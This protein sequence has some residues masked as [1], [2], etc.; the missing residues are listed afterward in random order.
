MRKALTM[1]FGDKAEVASGS[2]ERRSGCMSMRECLMKIGRQR[3][4]AVLLLCCALVF[5]TFPFPELTF[6]APASASVSKLV[7]KPAET[8]ALSEDSLGR[9]TPYGTV[10]GF[11]SAAERKDYQRASQ[12]LE[13]AQSTKK[14]EEL[15]RLLKLVLDRGLKPKWESL[16]RTPEGNL[17]EGILSNLE[18]V[19]T[20][21]Y[22]EESLDIILRRVD[23]KGAASIWLFSSE[24]LSGIPDA[25]EQ[26]IP[27]FVEKILPKGFMETRFGLLPLPVWIFIIILLPLL[28]GFSWLLARGLI[29]LLRPML[30][31]RIKELT[32]SDAAR[33]K[34]PITLLI[35]ALLLRMLAPLSAYIYYRMFW[36]GVAIVL[37]IVALT[38]FL[39]RLTMLV[40]G[41]R[42][43]RLREEQLLNQIALTELVTWLL[44]GLW[45]IVGLLLLLKNAGFELTTAIAGLSIFGV[46]IAFAAQKTIENLFGAVTVITDEPIRVGDFCQV[47]NIEG[48]VESIGL[49][50][51]RIRTLNRTL[52]T[53]PN[54]QL[55]TMSIENLAHR[56]KFLFRHKF[57]LRYETTAEQLSRVLAGIRTM[58][59]NHPK[60]EQ[61]T[62]R[63]R[64]VRFGDFSLDVEVFAYVLTPDWPGFLAEQED[65]L[66]LVMGIIEA[67][68]TSFAFPS[69]TMYITSD[70]GRA[71]LKIGG[72]VL[73][74]KAGG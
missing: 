33:L 36:R 66:V 1:N 15:A 2:N 44:Q 74:E 68:G 62:H 4:L 61:A 6:A 18:N 27:H 43:T 60:V 28:L 34:G 48:T 38:W 14:K 53:I 56:D 8:Q 54:G 5:L 24:T 51:T 47:G 45:I 17:D 21:K 23:Q 41:L 57:G 65:L 46:A 39:V 58:L 35:F 37:M 11:I 63:T 71:A 12:Y 20:A 32:R 50:S 59:S 67:S 64:F 13:S 3:S 52:V 72:S 29:R 69:Q 42:I 22:E 25:A 19:G 30:L 9:S 10:M 16:S 31:S 55:S 40:R 73:P 26:L 7:N 70:T 49:R